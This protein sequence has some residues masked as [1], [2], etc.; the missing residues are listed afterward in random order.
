MELLSIY[1]ESSLLKK[2]LSDK[3]VQVELGVEN[4]ELGHVLLNYATMHA[5]S[6]LIGVDAK[7]IQHF[8]KGYSTD[9]HFSK[10]LSSPKVKENRENPAFPQYYI[11]DEGL[12]FFE[13]SL[14][15]SR[16]YTR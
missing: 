2:E 11:S 15:R 16:L 4:K 7:E 3:S 1:V 10:V 12:V 8:V 14:G 9:L 13:D 5:Y 6:V